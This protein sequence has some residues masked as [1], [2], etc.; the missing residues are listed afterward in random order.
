MRF[1]SDDAL[2]SASKLKLLTAEHK[3]II[4]NLLT[5]QWAEEQQAVSNL[6]QNSWLIPEDI[7]DPILIKGRG[8]LSN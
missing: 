7:R 6:L 2:N 8:N 5:T 4:K 1:L 3:D